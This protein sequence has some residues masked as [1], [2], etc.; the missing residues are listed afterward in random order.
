[1]TYQFNSDNF[2]A[3]LVALVQAFQRENPG[4]DYSCVM[5]NGT[6]VSIKRGKPKAAKRPRT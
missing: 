1:M 2:E 4:I 6:K 3:A 5:H